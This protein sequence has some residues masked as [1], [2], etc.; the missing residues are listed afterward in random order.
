MGNGSRA[1]AL[2]RRRASRL[3]A[4][5]KKALR[6]AGHFVPARVRARLGLA[7]RE[8]VRW[9]NLRR[10]APFDRRWGLGRGTPV[11]RIYIEGFLYEHRSDMTGDC[12]EVMNRDYTQRYGGDS[13]VHSDVLD[14][15]PTNEL[16]TVVADL[17]APSSLPEAR[18]DCFIFTQ[19]LHLIPD[20]RIA[21]ANC[22][23]ALRPGGVLLVTVP[24]LG[25]HVTAEG[26]EHDRWRVTPS[27]LRW[28][29]AELPEAEFEVT[30][31]GNVLACA[32]LLYGVSAEEL[33][34][35]E[36]DEHDEEYP[37]I[38][39]ARIRKQRAP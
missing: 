33:S 4:P 17:G 20:M 19:T 32:A 36:V 12:L 27:G 39:A 1:V 35:R 7:A 37:L 31:F 11:D 8:R 2:L 34:P 5:V 9:G 28:M 15:D 21:L 24:T 25:V 22:W 26:F 6:H 16:A 29:L 13:V 3:P 30:S 23:R 10:T 38:V 14:L 18:Y